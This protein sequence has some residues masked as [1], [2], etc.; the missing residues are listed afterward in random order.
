MLAAVLEHMSDR[1]VAGGR[2]DLLELARIPFV[3]GRTARA[4][5]ENGF[6][7]LRMVAEA[8]V[9]AIAQVLLLAAPSRWKTSG[10]REAGYLEKM[11]ERAEV[12][13]REAGKM[14]ER[15]FVVEEEG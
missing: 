10:D 2:G 1:L 11:R 8:D 9:E 12:V 4:L 5:W 15:E 13:V 7:S 3:K 14:W 6:K